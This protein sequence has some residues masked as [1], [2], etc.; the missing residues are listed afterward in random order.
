ESITIGAKL[1]DEEYEESFISVKQHYFDEKDLSDYKDNVKQ[2]PFIFNNYLIISKLDKPVHIKNDASRD[3][4][5]EKFSEIVYEPDNYSYWS[6]NKELNV[7]IFFQN[8]KDRPV[9]YN[10]NGLVLLYLNDKN[11]VEY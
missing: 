8:K 2:K 10:Q 9:Y 5:E 11:E 3:S 4:I 7:I 6:W 1:P